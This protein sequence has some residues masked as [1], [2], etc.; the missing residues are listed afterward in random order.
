MSTKETSEQNLNLGKILMAIENL[1]SR[2]TADGVSK[3]VHGVGIQEDKD[4]KDKKDKD[5][6]YVLYFLLERTEEQKRW[7]IKG[8]REPR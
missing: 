2:C 4:K 1:Y 3:I 6:F 5:V 8:L 7:Q